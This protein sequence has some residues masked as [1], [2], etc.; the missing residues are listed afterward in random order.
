MGGVI[1][2]SLPI[3]HADTTSRTL[4]LGIIVA[5]VAVVAL[6][7]FFYESYQPVTI[8]GT[9]GSHFGPGLEVVFQSSSGRN[10]TSAVSEGSWTLRSIPNQQSYSVYVRYSYLSQTPEWCYY[11]VVK[12]AGFSAILN[13]NSSEGLSGV[14][15]SC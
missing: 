14:D 1:H 10:Y 15:L 4:L 3:G 5:L 2:D 11:G 12:L 7:A 13:G 8:S 6:S 9:A